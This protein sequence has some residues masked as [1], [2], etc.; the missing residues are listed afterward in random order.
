MPTNCCAKPT[1]PLYQAKLAG[2]NRMHLFDAQHDRSVRGHHESVQRIAQALA[3]GEFVLYFQP[4]VDMVAGHV[5]GAE[6]LIRWQH[7]QRGLLPPAVF[8]VI[9]DHALAIELG[10]WVIDQALR[11]VAAWQSEV[12]PCRSASISVPG[13]CSRPILSSGCSACWPVTPRWR[14]ACWSWRCWKP[15]PSKTSPTSPA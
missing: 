5:V 12:W 10:E 3:A 13:S 11:Q 14:R 4:K 8:R 1:R 7:P 2:K 9:E 6:A 15:A